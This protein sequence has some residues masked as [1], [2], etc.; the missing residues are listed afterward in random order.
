MQNPTLPLQTPDHGHSHWGWVD[1]GS[2]C[3]ES[4]LLGVPVGDGVVFEARDPVQPV[5][6]PD[7]LE[8][9][10]VVQRGSKGFVDENR[11]LGTLGISGLNGVSVAMAATCQAWLHTHERTRLECLNGCC[12]GHSDQVSI[13]V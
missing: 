9:L 1:T 4:V 7:S 11:A 13:S 3:E 8:A 6:Q 10:D 2:G 5:D 12:S